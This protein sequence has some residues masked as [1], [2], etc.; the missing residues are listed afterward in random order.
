MK[1]RIGLFII[2]T[3]LAALLLSVT[4][5][6]DESF[7]PGSSAVYFVNNAGGSDTNAGTS[8]AAPLKTLGKAYSYIRQAKGGTIVIS[9][10]V[11]IASAFAPSDAGGTVVYT[12]VYD[13]VNYAETNG[14]KLSIAANMAFSN[15]TY[16]QSICL[17][18]TKS[19]LSFS[20][21]CH[22]F[23]FGSGV[24]VLNGSGTDSFTY[25]VLV[26]GWNSP[27]TLAGAT[28]ANDYTVS[29]YSGTWSAVYGGHRR[30]ASSQPI[31]CLGGDVAVDIRGGTF[32]DVVSATGMNV[33]SG[34]VCLRISGGTFGGQV[35]A[36]RRLGTIESSTAKTDEAFTAVILVEISGG[37]FQS[38]FRLAES[39]V[40]TT[41]TTYPPFGDATVVITGGSFAGN[42]LGYGVAGSTLLKYDDSVLSESQIAGFPAYKTGSQSTSSA[43]TEK[44]RFTNPIGTHPDPYVTEKD[45]I[46]YYCFSSS[47]TVDGVGY[48]AVRVAAHGS[49]PFGNLSAQSRVV[50][51]AS[52][53]TDAN[54][55]HDY[56][57]PELHYFDAATVG[58]ANA[59][60]YIYVAADDGEN[61]NH[62][63]YVLRATEPENPLSDYEML[64]KITDSTD[65]WAI[66]G[67]VLQ[68]DGSLYFVWSG[69]EGTTN[70]R[71]NI[72]IA[73]MSD[74]WTISS[75]RVLLSTPSY[76]WETYDTPDVNEGPQILQYGG[77]THI[78]YSASGS[79]TRYYC[80]GMLTLTGDN[81]LAVSSW[82]KA[83]SPVFQS[84]N[85]IYG[86]GHGTFVQDD[87]GNWWMIYHANASLEI[88]DG[89]SWWAERN[90]Y[91]K[92]FSFTTETI[93]DKSYSYP[94]F[95]TPAAD[96]GTQY[97]YVRTADYH[98]DGE[99]FWLPSKQV[100]D[101][102]TVKLVRTCC[103]CDA[104]DV[105]L[106][107]EAPA[108]G[109]ALTA[110]GIRLTASDGASEYRFYR[111]TDGS[112]FSQIAETTEPV[113]T[114]TTAVAGTTYFYRCLAYSSDGSAV[115]VSPLSATVN[116]VWEVFAE[117]T[118]GAIYDA[119]AKRAGANDFI[120]FAR[121]GTSDE[122]LVEISGGSDA[123]YV[124]CVI[125][126]YI[127]PAKGNTESGGRRRIELTRADT[128]AIVFSDTPL[129][130]YGDVNADGV[131]SLIDVLSTLKY[132]A[133]QTI[134]VDVAAA[135][136]NFDCAV[137][138]ADALRT[139][140][141][142]LNGSPI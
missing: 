77:T 66:D 92:P 39:T 139:L 56:W 1:K 17:N 85:G 55:Q 121:V 45:G 137:G 5:F 97:I 134:E 104:T 40:A 140:H 136:S 124:Y 133:G 44:A 112:T 132:A 127:V 9:G 31:G 59:G 107:L 102:S 67:T 36:V 47:A 14:A 128:E 65:R 60:W 82:Y 26:G 7:A 3:A 68:L 81:P 34:R 25:P 69:W 90:T 86:P 120:L 42:V 84:G 2:S 72:Y 117:T 98:A 126:D 41:G 73:K 106:Q 23:G 111:S 52:M 12:S 122:L 38:N 62:R 46:Y 43:A 114:D 6:A 87:G 141:A 79:W 88:P 15:D 37:S 105:V 130:R 53:T 96:G 123:E 30:T 135:D 94:S 21:R 89:S 49:V 58:T 91:A 99:H 54:A 129:V 28:N 51:N 4:A 118:D 109:T 70:I 74:P 32:K 63:M 16:F 95:G 142:V 24:T 103:I 138:I 131:L 33:H 78:V 35:E 64:G 101:G 110:D 13:G 50:F 18:V 11:S 125:G 71:Q 100:S 10:T 61:A 8:A 108:L 57:A 75:E 119:V 93:D 80:Y 76:S 116:A 115:I 22:N 48:A 27:G 113:Y 83:T 20:G 19:T 29:V